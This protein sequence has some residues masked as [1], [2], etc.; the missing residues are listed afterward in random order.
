MRGKSWVNPRARFVDNI[1]VSNE[2][3]PDE[4]L[5][6]NEAHAWS[7]I[8]RSLRAQLPLRQIER[9]ARLHGDRTLVMAG[10]G[11]L[12]GLVLAGAV[13]LTA[14]A[15]IGLALMVAGGCFWVVLFR[16]AQDLLS[17]PSPYARPHFLASRRL[18]L[19]RGR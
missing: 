18:R 2:P 16:A 15:V 6:P 5:S 1:G 8:E 4:T 17:P 19:R 10:S 13:A 14:Q 3:G 9:R 12:G 7:V 11:V